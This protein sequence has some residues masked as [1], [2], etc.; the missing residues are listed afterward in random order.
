M[1]SKH[2]SRRIL[3]TLDP[4]QWRRKKFWRPVFQTD[5][6]RASYLADGTL[7]EWEWPEFSYDKSGI[8]AHCRR[9]V[10]RGLPVAV[11]VETD[12]K[13]PLIAK[14]THISICDTKGGFS[15]VW[16]PDDKETINALQGVFHACTLIMHNGSYDEEVLRNHSFYAPCGHDTM[17]A[18][19]VVAPLLPHGLEKVS[20]F[21][22]AL[23]KWKTNHKAGLSDR[24]VYNAKDTYSTALIWPRLSKHL[25]N[26]H[27]GW[28]LYTEYMDLARITMEMRARGVS[29]NKKA[30]R[31]HREKLQSRMKVSEREFNELMKTLNSTAKL[32]KNGQHPSLKPLFFKTLKCIPKQYTEKGKPVLDAGYIKDC[33]GHES[34]FVRELAKTILKFRQDAKLL[35]TYVDGLPMDYRNVVHPSFKV[36]GAI[37][38][39][40]SSSSPNFQNIPKIMRDMFI[41]RKDSWIV[42]ADYS[43]LELGIVALLAGDKDLINAFNRGE[44]LHEINSRTLF[45]DYNE[46]FRKFAKNSVYAFNYGADPENTYRRLKPDF[47]TLTLRHLKACHRRWFEAHPAI[48]EF[49]K[50][51]MYIA[52]GHLYVEAPLSGRRE[53]FYDRVEPPKVYNFPIQATAADLMNR[54]VKD[55]YPKLDWPYE[56]IMAQVHDELDLEGRD[57][58]RLFRLLKESMEQEI[59]YKGNRLK[60]RVDAAIG[61]DWAH[62][63]EV[64]DEAALIR[65]VNVN[66]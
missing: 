45:G 28:E 61:K 66:S 52:E 50:E 13:N 26:T 33:Q 20:S 59:E 21:E 1:L 18:H 15:W 8:M 23:E 46:D 24:A 30:I 44:D 22:F 49:H 34:P 10:S 38:G 40:W 11:D 29:V 54:A 4:G 58:L 48:K 56:A 19:A 32:G 65:Y 43:K 12:S 27:E 55:L 2:Y 53:Y 51:L 31:K 36:F 42:K 57:P 41:P 60:F 25:E 62:L 5:V 6:K 3:P 63:T 47:P 37:T 7:P 39:R 14:L 17:L 9:F 64:E 16:D 35:S